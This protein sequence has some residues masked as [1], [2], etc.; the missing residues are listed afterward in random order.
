VKNGIAQSVAEAVY[1]DIEYFARYGFNKAH[2]ADYAVMTCQTAYLKAHYP[3][4]YMTALM[5]VEQSI[6]K[7]GLLIVECRRM[8]IDVLPLTSTIAISLSRSKRDLTAN[9]RFDSAWHRS[10]AWAKARSR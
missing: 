6:E 1:G 8:G 10:R 5:T 3:V 7:I 4:E 9:A 2:A